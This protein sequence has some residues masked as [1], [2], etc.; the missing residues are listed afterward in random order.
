M[1]AMPW[2]ISVCPSIT[3]RVQR[4]RIN[5]QDDLMEPTIGAAFGPLWVALLVPFKT[6]RQKN[7]NRLTRYNPSAQQPR[8]PAHALPLPPPHHWCLFSSHFCPS[9]FK[10][11]THTLT[12]TISTT[13][14]WYLQNTSVCQTWYRT[15]VP[16][17]GENAAQQS[18]CDIEAMLSNKEKDGLNTVVVIP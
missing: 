11:L 4:G 15:A 14:S 10:I 7:E 6:H 9:S 16:S 18:Q 13:G 12:I 8:L 3:R 2:R 5:H 1:K 17:A